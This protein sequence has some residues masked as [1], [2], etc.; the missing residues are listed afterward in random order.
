[1]EYLDPVA[2]LLSSTV[3][4]A[5]SPATTGTSL[6]VQTV[7][8][9]NFPDP[10]T[11]GEYNLVLNPAG[12]DA[13]RTNAEIVRVTAKTGG[14]VLTITR[15][16]EGTTAKTVEVG[17]EVSMNMTAKMFEDVD[18][19]LGN[20]NAAIPTDFSDL[21]GA[22]TNAQMADMTTK[23]YKGR[24]AGTT[25]A[26]EDVSTATLKADLALT[27]SDVGLGNVDNVQ[28]LPSSYLDTDGAL[29]ANSDTKVASQKATKTYADTKLAKATNVTEIDDA[30]IADGEVAI[31][32]LTNK[33][34]K[35]SDKTL[36][37]GDIVGTTDPQTLSGKTLTSPLFEGTW[38]GWIDAK[39]TWTYASADD[40]T[41][42]FTISGDLSGKYSAGM[43][44]KLTQT[45]VKYFII[46]KVAYSSPNTTITVYGGTDYDLTS[47]TITSPYYSMVKAP[48]GFPLSPSKWTVT[49]TGD[50]S[51]SS[52]TAGTVYNVLSLSIP[53][54][55][56]DCVYLA[57][58][59]CK[60]F[61]ANW[62]IDVR[63]KIGVG[64]AN[65]NFTITSDILQLEIPDFQTSGYYTGFSS[66][67]TYSEN[68]DLTS[69]TTRYLNISP[70]DL[71]AATHRI[72]ASGIIIRA[73]CAYL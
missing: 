14:G 32:D 66:K 62:R 58:L 55:S 20:V 15:A 49:A 44:V 18:T 7:D 69:K 64:T 50:Y 23:T 46:T 48:Q 33:K 39:E 8:A 59:Y 65:N 24:T 31:F 68:I 37:T 6:Q 9:D 63:G 60:Y 41:Y 16:Q 35:T 45:T 72:Y 30:G 5:P 34:I 1:M 2:N 71:G 17:W 10:A 51:N 25:G 36:P 52:A 38:N 21:S 40:P 43:R 13:S 3:L 70:Q 73:T 22:I 26:P 19:E 61:G 4:T 28:Q 11:Y 56:W 53:I 54:G 42:T 67:W 12:Y 57:R 47:A 27:S 29:A